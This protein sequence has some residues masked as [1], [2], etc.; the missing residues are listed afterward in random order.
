MITTENLFDILVSFIGIGVSRTCGDDGP[1][2]FALFTNVTEGIA[3]RLKD[4]YREPFL[5]S[6]KYVIDEVDEGS[7]NGGHS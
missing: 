6:I 7:N 1:K 5:N 2:A 4:E 3:D